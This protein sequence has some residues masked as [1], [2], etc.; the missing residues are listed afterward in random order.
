MSGRSEIEADRRFFPNPEQCAAIE[1]PADDWLLVE[2]GPGT[3]KTQV[4]AM[5]LV[6]LLHNG[7]Q[8]AQILVLSFS[9]SAVATL[10][11]RIAALALGD[12]DTVEDLRHIA[13]RTFDSWAFRI[14]RQG[15][16]PPTELLSHSH[17]ENIASVTEALDRGEALEERLASIRHV[18]VDEFQDLPGVR[19]EMVAA[20]LARLNSVPSTRV[21]FTVLGDPAQA[22]YRFAAR[23]GNVGAVSDPWADLRKRMGLHIRE[24]ALT[25]NHRSTEQLAKMAASLR[26]ILG[27]PE[28]DAAAKLAA[29]NRFIGGL[30]SSGSDAKLSSEWLSQL[31]TG[32]LAILTRTNGEAIRVWQML[33]GRSFEGPQVTVRLRLAG[34]APSTPAWI[35]ATLSRYRPGTITKAVFDK[36]HQR[37]C[38]DLGAP[39]REKLRLPPVEVAWKRLAL[40]SG[41][42]EIAT[43]IDLDQLRSRLHWPDSF[44]DDQENGPV[45]VYITTV[46]QAKGMEFDNVALLEPHAREDEE[47]AEDPLEEANVGFVAVTRAARYLGRLPSTCIY[48][49]P[50]NRRFQ[51]GRVR[52]VQWA[53]MVNVQ[54]G[55]AGDID[56][57]SFVDPAVLGGDDEVRE[58]QGRLLAH[59]AE[60]RGHKVLLRK[61]S[62]P[63]G[64]GD[65]HR[66]L[67]DI[68]LQTSEAEGMLVGRTSDQVTRDLLDLLWKHGY[69]LPKTIYNLRIAD[70]VS[71][72]SDG[73]LPAMMPDPWKTSRL[74]LGVSL[75]GSGDFKTWKRNGK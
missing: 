45:A 62:V 19:A 71:V 64:K 43:V 67:Y 23:N 56:G 8:P 18:I 4:A 68:H 35:A 44:P 73:D 15:G 60:W 70:V 34:S 30:P 5:R 58:L 63:I 37:I 21:G 12:E 59:A 9:R 47:A 54:M 39:I 13:I 55:L 7:L 65:L 74:W 50:S 26:K 40:A 51:H 32:S 28:L 66:V 16:A 41:A 57:T 49:P 53:K 22:I 42:S 10:S 2:A 25:R 61:T 36:L 72:G 33:L 11:R 46:H 52:Q 20:L 24:I 14:L 6:H 29:M 17:D 38:V 27:A 3:G 69:D 75:M 1:A 48:K 31:P